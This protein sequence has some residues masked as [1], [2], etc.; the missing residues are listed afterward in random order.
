MRLTQDQYLALDHEGRQAYL[1]E[2]INAMGV[3]ED[4]LTADAKAIFMYQLTA[5][6]WVLM[7]KVLNRF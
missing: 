6:M 4:S 3:R 5:H 2:E 1:R 7:R